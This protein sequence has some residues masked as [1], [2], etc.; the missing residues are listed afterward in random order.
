V[1]SGP[2]PHGSAAQ[3]RELFS[4]RA[5]AALNDRGEEFV[6]LLVE[7]SVK[8]ARRHGAEQ[9]SAGD[10]QRAGLYL[11]AALGRTAWRRVETLGGLLAGAGLSQFVSMTANNQ[12]TPIG[13]WWSFGLT[14]VGG[15]LIAASWGRE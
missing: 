9:V 13:V 5:A 6:R 12:Y 15:A 11:A 4:V 1:S 10:V 14:V 7:E 3:D 8:T 2:P